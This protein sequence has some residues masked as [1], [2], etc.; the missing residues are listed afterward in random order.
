MPLRFPLSPI[1]LPLPVWRSS[2]PRALVRSPH[3]PVPLSLNPFAVATP[4]LAAELEMTFAPA[5]RE[6][7]SGW[8]PLLSK[9][10][11]CPMPES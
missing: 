3:M 9:G 6:V 8:W 4:Q 7:S 11:E 2:P 1:L 5:L 10:G